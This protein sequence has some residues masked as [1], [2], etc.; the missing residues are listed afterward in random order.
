MNRQE[1]LRVFLDASEDLITSKYILADIKIVNLLKSI[2]S[3]DSLLALFKNCLE[4]FDYDLA[5]KKYLIKNK[6]F[7]DD[8]GEFI[9]P[10]SARELLAFVFCILMDIDAKRIIFGE[11][12]NK[13]FYED[14]SY[15]ASFSAF[16]NA[17]IRPF[18]N[19]VKALM[20]SVIE[21]KLEDPIDA[22]T[23]QE[24]LAKKQK[25][26]RERQEKLDKELSEKAYGDSVKEIRKILLDDKNKVKA[27]NFSEEEKDQIILVI[28]RLAN[29]IEQTEATAKDDII[30]AFVA[31]MYMT[32]SHKFFFRGRAKKVARLLVGVLNAI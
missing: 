29:A 30:H 3:S 23:K 8:K 4:G 31:Y 28:D 27:K 26:E 20:H 14:G 22:L 7:S 32:K 9:L 17:M 16:T 19:T 15:S 25:L 2:A 18:A 12:L 5:S 6:Y 1:E 24:E 11:F 13:Y 21:G 10:Q